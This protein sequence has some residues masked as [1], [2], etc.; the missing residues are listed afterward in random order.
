MAHTLKEELI[1]WLKSLEGVPPNEQAWMKKLVTLLS[2]PNVTIPETAKAKEQVCQF[3]AR[4]VRMTP[5]IETPANAKRL[6]DFA[7]QF[8]LNEILNTAHIDRSS[9]RSKL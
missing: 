4:V 7:M 2:N 6:Y 1:Q 8:Q 9:Y 3:I 5:E